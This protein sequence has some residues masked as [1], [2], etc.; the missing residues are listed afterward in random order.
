MATSD[1]LCWM[2]ASQMA[3]AIKRRTLSPVEVVKAV[4]AREKS[5]LQSG[6]Q[7]PYTGSSPATLSTTTSC[8][9]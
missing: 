5:A 9:L 8:R 1:D 4:L 7:A 3:P 2:P 6:A